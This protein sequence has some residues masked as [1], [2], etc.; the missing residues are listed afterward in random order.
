MKEKR[1]AVLLA[2]V[3][4]GAVTLP[5]S[6]AAADNA[7]A[8]ALLPIGR[9]LLQEALAEEKTGK[10]R[11]D[12]GDRDF[13][14]ASMCADN[15]LL[16]SC[17]FPG[18]LCGGVDRNGAVVVAPVYDFVD[19][20]RQGRAI[21]RTGR[22]YGVV[23]TTGRLIAPVEY[24]EVEF[25]SRDLFLVVRD[26]KTGLTDFDGRS[27]VEPRFSVIRPIGPDVIWLVESPAIIQ[28]LPPDSLPDASNRFIIPGMGRF[29]FPPNLRLV[30]CGLAAR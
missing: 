20:F 7:D 11:Q 25:F 1:V 21:V 22:L 18:G 6:S 16:P 14:G 2:T 30:P 19:V 27:V 28:P 13:T 24:D 4:A 15:F 5:G 29:S 8:R 9:I 17:A 23:D 26:G 12:I 10:P 3:L